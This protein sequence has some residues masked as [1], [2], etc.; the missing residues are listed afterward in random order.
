[1]NPQL[2]SAVRAIYQGA[3]EEFVARRDALAKQLR[4]AG[5]RDAAASVKSLRKPSRAAWALDLG[6][7]AAPDAM[8]ALVAAADGTLQ[9]QVSGGDVRT[10]ISRL[11][12]AIRDLADAAAAAAAR[13]GHPTDPALLASAIL[14]VIGRPDHFDQ[15]RGGVLCDVPEAGGLDFLSALPA[16]GPAA[17][18]TSRNADP[19]V[20][21]LAARDAE[22]KA[23]RALAQARER[24]DAAQRTLEQAEA[25][26][27]AAETDL[28]QA[29]A[30]VREARARRKAAQ[31]DA[32]AAAQELRAALD[33]V[34]HA[35]Q[36]LRQARP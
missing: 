36:R 19:D 26:L 4:A 24:A 16:P 12:A 2:V 32:G 22:R 31:R 15:L 17:A 1:M 18:A 30:A 27:A 13:A 33:E 29:E 14:A 3:L 6:A 25:G 21:D 9:A 28:E 34:H 7:G 23:A 11:R 20:I 35:E 10:A 5:D 8:D